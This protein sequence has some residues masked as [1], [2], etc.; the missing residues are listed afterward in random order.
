MVRVWGSAGVLRLWHA[1][2]DA[3]KNLGGP[4]GSWLLEGVL[5]GI[6]ILRHRRGNPD[7]ELCRNLSGAPE[8][9]GR[10]AE[11]YCERESLPHADG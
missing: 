4:V 6:R 7:T 3:S 8:S 11:E 9:S 10:K 5:D 1:G 2:T